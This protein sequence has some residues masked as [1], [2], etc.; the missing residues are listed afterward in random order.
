MVFQRPCGTLAA[1]L[2]PRG[3]HPR[4]GAMFVLV[5]TQA[6]AIAE[7]SRDPAEQ[8]RS[9]TDR[10]PPRTDTT[11]AGSK[12]GRLR[13]AYS[14]PADA[15]RSRQPR[16]G[17][18]RRRN[19]ASVAR[20]HIPLLA[21]RGDR[22][23]GF[24]VERRGSRIEGASFPASPGQRRGKCSPGGSPKIGIARTMAM[25]N[26]RRTVPK[27]GMVGVP[28]S[29]RSAGRRRRINNG[30]TSGG[31]VRFIRLQRKASQQIVKRRCPGWRCILRARGR[32]ANP[33]SANGF[34]EQDRVGHGR[35]MRDARTGSG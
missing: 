29:V 31:P 27:S 30:V 15:A 28:S 16:I 9:P 24:L 18:T 6:A 7:I 33:G 1:S 3:A 22:L 25:L 5:W 26:T 2:R 21:M 19:T 35:Q 32:R 14:A 17:T 34:E 23:H 11:A 12:P 8:L 20:R 13:I 4:S 10:D